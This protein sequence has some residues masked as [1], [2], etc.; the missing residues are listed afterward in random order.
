MI[1]LWTSKDALLSSTRKNGVLD[2][3]RLGTAAYSAFVRVGT[4]L[5]PDDFVSRYPDFPGWEKVTFR[6]YDQRKRALE[7]YTLFEGD[8]TPSRR[9]LADHD[10]KIEAP[11]RAYIDLETDSRVPPREQAEFGRGRIVSW[12]L[13]DEEGLEEVQVLESDD[14]LCEAQMLE[15]LWTRMAE[16]D[17][18]AAWSGDDFDFPVIEHRSQLLL[19]KCK[20]YWETR[21]RLLFV[22][23]LACFKRHHMAP[24][25]GDDKTSMKLGA[26]CEA[27]IGE[28]KNDFDARKTW[29]SW[30]SK[31][32]RLPLYNLQDTVLLRKLEASTGYLALHQAVGEATYTPVN[33]HGLKP[34]CYVDGFMLRLA[35]ERQTHLPSKKQPTGN[36]EQYEGALVIPPQA[37]G[38]HRTVHV[39]DFTSLYPTVLRTFN[40]SPETKDLL[41]CTA[42]GTGVSFGVD[43]EGMLPAGARALMEGRDFWKKKAKADPNDKFAERMNKGFKIVCNTLYG[44]LGSPW[45]RYYDPQIAESIT[46]GAV[47]LLKSTI[48]EAELRG[49]KN[50]Y[51]DTDSCFILGPSV[52]EFKQFVSQCNTD[53]Y[54]KML[55]DQGCPRKFQC[56]NLDYEKCFDRLVFPLGAGGSPSSKRYFGSY[57]HYAFKPKTKPEIRGLEYMRGDGLRLARHMQ[58]DA[59]D[60]ILAGQSSEELEEWVLGMRRRVMN[61]KLP[62]EEILISK[63]LG[64]ELKDYKNLPP[65]V[66]LAIEQEAAGEDIGQGSK[67]SYVIADGGVSPMRIIAADQYDGTF[68]RHFTWQK[69]VY[70]CILRILAGSFQD[71]NWRR[72]IGKRPKAPLVGQMGLSLT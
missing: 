43:E 38:V 70:P 28:G 5:D 68:D 20:L 8:V 11:R 44:V 67:I 47:H 62:V 15:A 33:S 6:D 48:A 13:V 58:K 61:E 30:E 34:M 69:Q 59:I 50:L 42:F 45:S 66:R 41:G 25:S 71:R 21:R 27:I 10:V 39:C 52:E 3:K 63:G 55:D 23:H 51:G 17:Q 49:W 18:I 36:E 1:N 26:V 14:D 60:R 56:I 9:Y 72:W 12:A 64:Q 29:E 31:D 57:L 65:H 19:R 40:I 46:L 22:D 16:Y 4:T 54:P 2:I 7:L 24:E 35:R 37:L 53:V 32:P